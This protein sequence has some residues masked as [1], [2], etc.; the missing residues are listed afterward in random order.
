MKL[1]REACARLHKAQPGMGKKVDFNEDPQRATEGWNT[2]I[3]D[4]DAG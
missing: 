2:V 3:Q 1:E 4:F